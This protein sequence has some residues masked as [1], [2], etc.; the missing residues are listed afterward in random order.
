MR[1]LTSLAPPPR[2]LWL[3]LAAAVGALA[4]WLWLHGLGRASFWHDEA[5][6]LRMI[7]RPL[8]EIW[9]FDDDIHPP[10]FFFLLYFWLDWVGFDEF[11]LRLL[12]V[13]FALAAL[14]AVYLIG[15][16]CGGPWLGL[17]TAAFFVSSPFVL[18]YAQELRAYTLLACAC[19]WAL[20]GFLRL[21]T[22]RARAALP[23]TAPGSDRLAWALLALGSVVALYTHNL[24]LLLPFTTSILALALWLPAPDRLRLAR[25]WTLVHLLVLLAWAPYLPALLHQTGLQ[26]FAWIAEPSLDTVLRTEALVAFGIRDL[27]N[28]WTWPALAGFL[29]LAVLGV[30]ALRGR[31]PIGALLLGAFFLPALGALLVSWVFSPVY[32]ARPLIWSEMPIAVLLGAGTMALLSQPRR[33]LVPAA[34][35]LLLLSLANAQNL[36][37]ELR[38]SGDNWRMVARAVAERALPGEPVVVPGL[39]GEPLAY[40]LRRIQVTEGK[41]VPQVIAVE[42]VLAT[43][44]IE[45]ARAPDPERYLLIETPWRPGRAGLL[46]MLRWRYPCHDIAGRSDSAGM[47]LWRYERRAGCAR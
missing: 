11:R 34:L 37:G 36:Q 40:Y 45:L 42:A 27:G 32:I 8:G 23:L 3:L 7:D 29:A 30:F 6:S 24:G 26:G 16:R 33:R 38:G 2:W 25:N 28:P 21:V 12:S 22:D 9:G 13:L 19:A 44:A 47:I 15:R 17:A 35:A 4:L 1:A 41:D 46:A 43:I 14:P 31:P 18:R 39:G 20:Y 10:L 5:F